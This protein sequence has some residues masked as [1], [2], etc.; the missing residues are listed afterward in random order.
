MAAVA[1][2]PSLPRRARKKLAVRE[3]LLAE[4]RRLLLAQGVAGTGVAEIA[5]AADVAPATFFNHFASKDALLAAL[6]ARAFE[7]LAAL[8]EASRAAHPADPAAQVASFFSGAAGALEPARAELGDLL[9]ALV[10][11]AATPPPGLDPLE[12]L[13][14]AW[15][16]LLF[17]AQRQGALRGDVEAAFLADLVVAALRGA[18]AEALRDP[19]YP[20]AR[21][22]AQLGAFVAGGLGLRAPADR[23]PSSHVEEYHS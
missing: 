7:P 13:R 22:L 8:V 15:S 11:R 4:A 9:L 18:L 20:L 10:R 1:Y 12:P 3:R 14:H 16:R 5:E 17:E 6:T 2:A 21:R 23:D 19:R